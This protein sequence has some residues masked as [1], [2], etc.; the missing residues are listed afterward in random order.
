[1]AINFNVLSTSMEDRIGDNMECGLI[2][3]I[4]ES[5][6]CLRKAKIS[7]KKTKLLHLTCG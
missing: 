3:A 1:M 2:V 7:E 6:M 4:D 5:R